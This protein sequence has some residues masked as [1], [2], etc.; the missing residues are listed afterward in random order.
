MCFGKLATNHDSLLFRGFN[1]YCLILLERENSESLSYTHLPTYP[2]T[3]ACK[4]V[5]FLLNLL[6]ITNVNVLRAKK[7]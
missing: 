2:Q 1:G 3:Q 4:D 6:L 7:F 5:F